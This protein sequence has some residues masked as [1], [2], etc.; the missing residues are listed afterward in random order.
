MA[1]PTVDELQTQVEQLTAQVADRDALLGHFAAGHEV[2][3]LCADLATKRDGTVFYAG[4]VE[5]DVAKA[6]PE[7]ADPE[8]ADPEK[9]DPEKASVDPQKAKKPTRRPASKADDKTKPPAYTPNTF[10]DNRTSL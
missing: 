4:D 10:G 7:K 9:A 6:D 5:A 1:E 3:A 8:K 2:D